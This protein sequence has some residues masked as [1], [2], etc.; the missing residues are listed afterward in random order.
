MG[1]PPPQ[2]LGGPSPQSPPKSPPWRL[3]PIGNTELEYNTTLEKTL[4]LIIHCKKQKT[5]LKLAK[6]NK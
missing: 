2:I 3:N 6:L 4:I 1:R 5:I